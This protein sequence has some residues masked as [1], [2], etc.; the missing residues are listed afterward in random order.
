MGKKNMRW[1]WLSACRKRQALPG[2]AKQGIDPGRTEVRKG[3]G[4]D[5]VAD[6]FWLPQGA[7]TASAPLLQGQP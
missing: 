4:K 5:H 6:I 3:T 1:I 7:D 2:T